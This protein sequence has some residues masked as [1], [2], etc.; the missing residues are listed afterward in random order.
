M[1]IVGGTLRGR[2]ISSPQDETTRPTSD[3]AREA[4]FNM[5]FSLGLPECAQVVDLFSGSGALGLEALSRGA[6]DVTFVDNNPGACKIIRA[7]LNSLDLGA[8]VILGDAVATLGSL[9]VDLVLAD[10]PYGFEDWQSLLAAAG[11]AVVVAESN[12]MVGPFE[13]WELIRTRSY[14]RAVITILR[15]G[16]TNMS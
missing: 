8:E 12:R 16:N 1:R 11:D 14:G 7:N 10:P 6:N 13:G 4:I 15:P 5:L 9:D 3:R 2:R